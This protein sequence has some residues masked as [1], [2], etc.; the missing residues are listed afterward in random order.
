M[1]NNMFDDYNP[2]DDD[3]IFDRDDLVG[4]SMINDDPV[5]KR[6]TVLKNLYNNI[7]DESV[8]DNGI[9]TVTS[10]IEDGIE[11]DETIPDA[12]LTNI[13]PDESDV[14]PDG[15]DAEEEIEAAQEIMTGEADEDVDILDLVENMD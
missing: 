15:M 5:F 8:V 11:V 1:I 12:D 13:E 10:A 9:N 2:S 6:H 7:V 4:I 14:S 3:E